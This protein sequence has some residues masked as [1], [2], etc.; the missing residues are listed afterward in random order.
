[1]VKREATGDIW[2]L[3]EYF[4]Y[5]NQNVNNVNWIQI[6]TDKRITSSKKNP[7]IREMINNNFLIVSLFDYLQGILKVWDLYEEIY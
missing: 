5:M 4:L 7:M 6:T 2:E 1:M 3:S